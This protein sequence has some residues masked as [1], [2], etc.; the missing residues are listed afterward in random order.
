MSVVLFSFIHP[1]SKIILESGIPLS[2]FCTLFVGIRILAISPYFIYNKKLPIPEKKDIPVL[3]LFGL[4][5]AAL[6]FFEFKGIAEGLPPGLVTF[7]MFSYPLW[8]YIIKV[9]KE[10]K[11]GFVKTMQ[12][13]SILAGLFLLTGSSFDEMKSYAVIYPVLASVAVAV[14]I[15]VSN[16]LT[17]SGIEPFS[18]SLHYDVF[19]CIALILLFGRDFL[20]EGSQFLNWIS[21]EGSLSLVGYAVLIGLLPNLLFYHGSKSVNSESAGGAMTFEPVVSTIYSYLIWGIV[22]GGGFWLGAFC[23]FLGNFP[24]QYFLKKTRKGEEGIALPT[25]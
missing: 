7:L 15:V 9:Y 19:S 11:V 5:G 22:L 4:A 3:L 13:G 20:Q 1:G 23:I 14:W 12:F 10:K 2:F 18:L 21:I 25:S 16:R 24:I 17:K 8:L 6:Q